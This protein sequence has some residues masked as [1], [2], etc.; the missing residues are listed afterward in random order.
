MIALGVS[1]KVSFDITL[2]LYG[3]SS[4]SSPLVCQGFQLKER[5]SVCELCTQEVTHQ[6]YI[7][8]FLGRGQNDLK[9]VW[10][11]TYFHFALQ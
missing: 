6:W 9:T 10:Q 3:I 4:L 8:H 2:H 11:L 1:R 5:E 7:R